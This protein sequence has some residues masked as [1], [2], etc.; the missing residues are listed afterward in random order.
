V[1]TLL[2]G[3]LVVEGACLLFVGFLMMENT[4][5]QTNKQTN[6]RKGAGQRTSSLFSFS[7]GHRL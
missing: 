6:K 3:A 4:N 1:F 5:K 2:L 7:V